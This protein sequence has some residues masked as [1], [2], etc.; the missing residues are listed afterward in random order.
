MKLSEFITNLQ[1][2]ESAGHGALDII[3]Y[4]PSSG[5]YYFPSPPSLDNVP[6]D[7]EQLLDHADLEVGE[8]FIRLTLDY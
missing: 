4:L 3:G 8:A 5:L 1:A 7:D 6:E 2:L